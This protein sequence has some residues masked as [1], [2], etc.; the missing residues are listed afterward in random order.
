M[1]NNS[2]KAAWW[3]PGR[4]GQTLWPVLTRRVPLDVRERLELPDGDFVPLDWVGKSGPIVVVLPGCRATWGRPTCGGC[5][6]PA[7][8]GAGAACC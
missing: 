7:R 2:F 1:E 4:H 3:L 8:R 5:C 6:G